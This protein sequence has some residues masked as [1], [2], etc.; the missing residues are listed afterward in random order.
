MALE[1]GRRDIRRLLARLGAF[2]RSLDQPVVGRR[3]PGS[4]VVGLTGLMLSLVAALLAY[5]TGSNTWYADSLSHL[6]I[7]RRI[8]DSQAPGFQQLG[9]VWLPLPHLLLIP[10]VANLWMWSSGVGASLLGAGCAAATATAVYRIAARLGFG[11]AGRLVAVLVLWTNVS[12]LYI[13]TTALTE[14]VLIAAFACTIAGLVHWATAARPMSGGELAVFAGLPAMVAMLS[15][16]EG[17]VLV[18]SMVVYI[19]AVEYR[20][21]GGRTQ[22]PWRFIALHRILPALAAP[23]FG[24][25]C[26][27]VGVGWWLAYNYAI[28]HDPLEFM[29]GPYSALR[30]QADD[31]A[32]GIVTTKG[33]LGISLTVYDWSLW[34]ILGGVVVVAG[35]LGF[36]L[37][38]FTEGLS[39]RVLTLGLAFSTYV[40]MVASLY[41]GQTV[42]WNDHSMPPSLWNVRFAVSPIV[43]FALGTAAFVDRLGGWLRR[44]PRSAGAPGR[45]LLAAG[46]AVVVALALLAQFGWWARDP[47]TRSPVVAEGHLSLVLRPTKVIDYLRRHYD[48]GHILMNESAPRNAIIPLVGLPNRDYWD[49]STG[50]GYDAALKSPTTHAT[51]IVVNTSLHT[52]Y[53]DPVYLYMRQHRELFANYDIV[54]KDGSEVLYHL[55]RWTP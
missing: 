51:W 39:I 26:P 35:A 25:L 17:W 13:C 21:M 4:A 47:G 50:A 10:F 6:T 55:D 49:V 24:V 48:G 3:V 44:T 31:I 23:A 19:A 27:F 41:L 11:R 42:I 52:D 20:R 9:T 8:F 18:V 16:Y 46:P 34:E 15:R 45:R 22:H 1:R 7:A 40:F 53:P 30:Q 5:R 36:L 33:N 54:A 12:Y 29:T 43:F 2:W 38:F 14:P 28:Y 32:R 37:L